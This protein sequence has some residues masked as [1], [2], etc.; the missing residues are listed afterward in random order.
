M[1]PNYSSLHQQ[2]LNAILK[3]A[4]KSANAASRDF[5]EKFYALAT[6]PD[7]EDMQPAY[8]AHIAREC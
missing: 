4:P 3:A 2:L 7:L 8:A 6:V 1:A 5:I